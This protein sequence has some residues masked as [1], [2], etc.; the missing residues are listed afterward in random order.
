MKGRMWRYQSRNHTQTE[1]MGM[2]K[3]P[4]IGLAESKSNPAKD[5]FADVIYDG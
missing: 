3:L 2:I 1:K 4:R 5:A